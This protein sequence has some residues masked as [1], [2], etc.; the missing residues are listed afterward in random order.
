MTTNDQRKLATQKDYS[1]ISKMY[2]DDFGT[3]RDHFDFIDQVIK[4]IKERKLDSLPMID[5]GCGSGVVTDY[6]EEK[7]L[8][9]IIAVDLTPEFCKMIEAKHGDKVKVICGD[10]VET[11]KNQKP[12]S[13]ASYFASFSIIH[14]P[15]EELDS[16]FTSI[17]L[18]LT[19]GGFFVMSCHKG[20]FKG[21][22]Q[23]PYQTQKD[24]RLT[25]NEELSAYIN[26]F[27]EEEL[28]KRITKAG[29]KVVRLETFEAKIVPGEFPAPKIWLLA[30]KQVE[31]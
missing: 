27:T 4:L 21:M 9:N 7:G 14:I 11:V 29:M 31:G 15:N 17:S 3:D 26:Y 19:S 30:E 2:A 12:S 1:K 25:E 22:E 18:S 5:L 16:L 6:L 10:M 28:T 8:Q 23:E 20:T 24:S 13:V